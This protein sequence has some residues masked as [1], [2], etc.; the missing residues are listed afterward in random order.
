[1]DYDEDFQADITPGMNSWYGDWTPAD[2]QQAQ[3]TDKRCYRCHRR[4][5]TDMDGG[6]C[7]QYF[8]NE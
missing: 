1:M 5:A 7:Q 6:L 2:L 4:P 3:D 8:D